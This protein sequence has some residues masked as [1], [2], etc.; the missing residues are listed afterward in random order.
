MTERLNR[1]NADGVEWPDL[2]DDGGRDETARAHA[3][4]QQNSPVSFAS[5]ELRHSVS[6]YSDAPSAGSKPLLVLDDSS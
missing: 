2:D 3:S 6:E 1:Q 4:P 5:D